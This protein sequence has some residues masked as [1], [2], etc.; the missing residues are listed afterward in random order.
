M[1]TRLQVEHPISEQ[2]V[3]IDLV[4]EQIKIADGNKLSFKQNDI[5][6]RGHAIECRICAEDAEN[7]F[8][9]SPGI[10]K[11]I[12][13]PL[14]L[15]VRVDSYVYDGYEIPI[16]YD[17][18]ISKLIVWS[19]SRNYAIKRMKRA[20]YEYK[21]IGIKNNISFLRR[22]FD[23][24]DFVNGK[25]NTHFI[26]KNYEEMMKPH[27]VS[28]AMTEDVAIIAAYIDYVMNLEDI[29]SIAIGE[30]RALSKWKDFGKQKGLLRI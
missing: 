19:D 26:E 24:E 28:K 23:T 6:Q 2:V 1:N 22:V 15:G 12:T 13:E 18:M 16:H 30:K 29:Q 5:V 21:I 10:I 9:P 11:H 7:N 25:Y 8:A 17:P 27:K 3:R 20:L 14:G 4:K